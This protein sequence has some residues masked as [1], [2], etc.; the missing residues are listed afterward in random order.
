MADQAS[1]LVVYQH[2]LLGEGV[3]TQL[4][5]MGARAMA[6][7]SGDPT[8]I[9]AALRPCP[10]LVVVETTDK[11]CIT[12]VRQLCPS[13][14]LV[15]VTASMG[16]GCPRSVVRFDAIADALWPDRATPETASRRR[17]AGDAS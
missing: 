1:V 9:A 16:R 2:E 15:D 12:R 7:S 10:D 8:A 3:A 11:T 14:R 6:V 13:S 5:G 4:R 17:R